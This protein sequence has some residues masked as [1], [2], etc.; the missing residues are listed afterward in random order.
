MKRQKVEIEYIGD[1][2]FLPDLT[3]YERGAGVGAI[4]FVRFPKKKA[5]A[6]KSKPARRTK[7]RKPK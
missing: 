1:P 4:G 7:S 3:V 6:R 2:Q 5:P